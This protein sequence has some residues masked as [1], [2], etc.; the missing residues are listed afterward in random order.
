MGAGLNDFVDG[1][2]GIL[3][4]PEAP[5]ALTLAQLDDLLALEGRLQ[6]LLEAASAGLAAAAASQARLARRGLGL[7]PGACAVVTNGRVVE[8]PGARPS[9]GDPAESAEPAEVLEPHDFE[10]LELQAQRGQYSAQV[11]ELVAATVEVRRRCDW[12]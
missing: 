12:V 7:D 9:S 6:G 8:L 1:L 2:D 11:A 5:S 3:R 10:L 4:A